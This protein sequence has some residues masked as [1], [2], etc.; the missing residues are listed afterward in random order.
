MSLETASI[1]AITLLVEDLVATKT[2]YHD[3]FGKDV[4]WEDEVSAGFRFG[5]TIINLLRVDQGPGLIGPARVAGPEVGARMQLT[6][7]VEDTD[8]TIAEL[9]ARGVELINGPIDR[10]WGQ[11]TA[12]FADPAGHIWEI[13][14]SI[15][16]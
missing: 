9:Q 10:A 5:D 2:F 16:V 3:V 11:R 1:G 15:T 7:W 13:A 8:A 6:I 12:T 4:M 14:Q